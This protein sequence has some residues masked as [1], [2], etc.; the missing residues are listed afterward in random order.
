MQSKRQEK[1]TK[2]IALLYKTLYRNTDKYSAKDITTAH[3]TNI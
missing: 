1:P 2:T 3:K